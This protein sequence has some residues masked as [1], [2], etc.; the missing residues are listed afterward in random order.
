V[1]HGH[2]GRKRRLGELERAALETEQA[3]GPA[4]VGDDERT[5]PARVAGA[6]AQVVDAS[7]EVACAEQELLGEEAER[8]LV[9]RAVAHDDGGDAL[10]VHAAQAAGL[11]GQDGL[12]AGE[13]ARV[14]RAAADDQTRRGIRRLEHRLETRAASECRGLDPRECLADEELRLIDPR[15]VGDPLDALALPGELR[16]ERAGALRAHPADER[17]PREPRQRGALARDVGADLGAQ[18]LALRPALLDRRACRRDR[19]AHRAGGG[20][21]CSTSFAEPIR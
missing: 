6:P 14:G 7:G 11:G 4:G 5:A 19:S 2:L 15:G 12:D 1:G 16:L 21:I 9:A 17:T 8:R 18:R 10:G 3:H 20:W 13:P